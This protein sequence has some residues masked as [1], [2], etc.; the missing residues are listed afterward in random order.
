MLLLSQLLESNQ[1]PSTSDGDNISTWLLTCS[2]VSSK[3]LPQ[4]CLGGEETDFSCLVGMEL[5]DVITSSVRSDIVIVNIIAARFKEYL[6]VHK[7]NL[8]CIVTKLCRPQLRR[9]L[10]EF[11]RL[12]YPRCQMLV[13]L[14][15]NKIKYAIREKKKGDL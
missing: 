4:V 13:K 9:T 5:N 15:D 6:S 2:I 1:Q 11:I 14:N 10:R 3:M 12:R 7:S 8:N